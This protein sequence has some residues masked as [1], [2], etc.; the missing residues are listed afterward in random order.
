MG[1]PYLMKEVILEMI[2][3][4]LGFREKRMLVKTNFLFYEKNVLPDR[5]GLNFEVTI[6]AVQM[7]I[8]NDNDILI[9]MSD[10][11]DM[12]NRNR[13]ARVNADKEFFGK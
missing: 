6:R 4:H 7:G 10:Y 8:D 3:M 13:V 2:N 11:I 9:N 5:N 12:L 1:M